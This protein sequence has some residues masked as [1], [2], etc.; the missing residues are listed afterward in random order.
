M[1]TYK[2]FFETAD[3]KDYVVKDDD[4]DEK[5]E[6]KPR[7]KGEKKFKDAHK[8]DKK[9]HPTADDSV[10]TGDIKKKV[11]EEVELEE[12]AKVKEDDEDEDED[13]VAGRGDED[14]E[15][16][17]DDDDDEEEIDEDV[18]GSLED[19]AKRHQAKRVKFG[20]KKSMTVDAT[21][22]NAMVSMFKKLN[23]QNKKR[24][25]PFIDKSP[26]NFMKMMD[27]AFGGG[28]K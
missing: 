8:V 13:E 27:L 16:S 21:T 3:A 6:L 2:Q 19:I 20:N 25:R 17:D 4:E 12:K 7:S 18:L 10:H 26:E 24:M 11:K 22:A 14:E 9:K 15:D 5:K 23:D 1:K 28:K